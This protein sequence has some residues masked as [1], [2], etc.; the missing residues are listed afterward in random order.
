MKWLLQKLQAQSPMIV[1]RSDRRKTEPRLKYVSLA[2][3]QCGAEDC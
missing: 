1:Q 2:A 3:W